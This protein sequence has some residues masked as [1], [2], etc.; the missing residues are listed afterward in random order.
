[1]LTRE[2]LNTL[3]CPY[4]GGAIRL[5]TD[6]DPAD[7]G[8]NWGTVRCACYRY[9]IVDGILMLRQDSSTANTLNKIVDLLDAGD[10]NGALAYA[11][12]ATSPVPAP[13]SFADAAEKGLRD[14]FGWR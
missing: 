5:D 12:S 1:M 10:R 11:L 8:L 7:K 2:F 6:P 4:C 14:V 13:R 3:H 9:P